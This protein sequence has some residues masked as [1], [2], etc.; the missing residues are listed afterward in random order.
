M[1]APVDNRSRVKREFKKFV[2][3][4]GLETVRNDP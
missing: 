1:S 3:L 2:S 4:A